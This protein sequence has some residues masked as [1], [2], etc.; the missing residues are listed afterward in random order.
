MKRYVSEARINT[1]PRQMVHV[2][3]S[4]DQEVRCHN[5]RELLPADGREQLTCP[6][7][8]RV[9]TLQPPIKPESTVDSAETK[10]WLEERY[11]VDALL[12]QGGGDREKVADELRD[13]RDQ[14]LQEADAAGPGWLAA[15]DLLDQAAKIERLR[16][17][18]LE[19]L[20]VQP[21]RSRRD[22]ADQGGG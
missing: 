3:Y 20:K 6:S 7:G 19:A 4:Q 5:C 11:L 21:H 1:S 17:L 8:C 14:K 2:V 12:R 22:N 16:V 13:A 10:R 9:Y 15:E 18:L